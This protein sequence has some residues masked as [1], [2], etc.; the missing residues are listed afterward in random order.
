MKLAA[1]SGSKLGSRRGAA[2]WLFNVLGN[3]IEEDA[4]S[5]RLG[6]WFVCNGPY[7][8]HLVKPV[9]GHPERIIKIKDVDRQERFDRFRG[10]GVLV[11]ARVSP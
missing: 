1:V 7:R 9:G 10:T 8:V 4:W 3:R 11:C 5:E 2:R 6:R